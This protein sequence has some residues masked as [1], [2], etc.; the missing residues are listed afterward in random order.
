MDQFAQRLREIRGSM[1]QTEF[2]ALTGISRASISNYEN[3]LRTPDITALR[4]LHEA[5]GVSVY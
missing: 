5:T 3:G 4:Q 1:T 2:S